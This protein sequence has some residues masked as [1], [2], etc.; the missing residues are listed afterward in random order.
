MNHSI[1]KAYLE[2]NK[3]QKDPEH[4]TPTPVEEVQA[5]IAK[6]KRRSKEREAS[7][8]YDNEPIILTGTEQKS[9]LRLFATEIMCDMLTNLLDLKNGVN[10]N[11]SNLN[12][13]LE[14]HQDDN[15]I[16]TDNIINNNISLLR[17]NL[18]RSFKYVIRQEDLQILTILE[19]TA[20]RKAMIPIYERLH[21]FYISESLTRHPENKKIDIMNKCIKMLL[22]CEVKGIYQKEKITTI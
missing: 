13:D 14:I 19:N 8:L 9:K 5:E 22:E 3:S 17:E 2:M 7:G 16:L 20:D 6:L 10:S 12:Y 21:S 4:I 18:E 1:I 15:L 11:S